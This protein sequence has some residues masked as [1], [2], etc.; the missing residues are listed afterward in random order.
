MNNSDYM[1]E[2]LKLAKFAFDQGEIPV[3]AV[4][5][6]EGNIIGRGYN[7]SIK[8]KDPS[9]HAEIV[10]LREASVFLNNYRLNGADLYSTLEPCLMWAGAMVHARIRKVFFSSHDLKSGV[11]ES[12]AKTFEFGFLNHKVCFQGG[13]KSKESS[14][15]LKDFFIEKRT[16]KLNSDHIGA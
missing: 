12:N 10:A 7:Q 3:G 2:A 11:V 13:L 6:L 8:N 4:I 16:H 5:V 9:S 14:K 15:L 1:E